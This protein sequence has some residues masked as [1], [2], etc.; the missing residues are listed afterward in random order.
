M[1]KKGKRNS[2]VPAL[3]SLALM[4][5]I[6]MLSAQ[7]GETS[8]ESSRFVTKIFSKLIFY[9]YGSMSPQH[10]AFI[11]A[12]LEWFVRK[13][14]HFSIYGLLG[15]NVFL[16]LHFLLRKLFGKTIL[17]VMV[18]AAYAAFDELHQSFVPGRSGHVFDVAI[19]TFGATCG[20]IAA[21]AVVGWL[22]YLQYPMTE[23]N[24]DLWGGRYTARAPECK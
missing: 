21:I 23:G 19:D 6:F 22:Y 16:S 1:N 2:T 4:V 3:L 20:I 18:C 8:S 13:L 24:E 15:F 10:Q 17:A 11:V 7:D 5:A 9:R 12:E 14:A